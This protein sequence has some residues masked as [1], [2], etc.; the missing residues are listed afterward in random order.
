M[1]RR[2]PLFI[3]LAIISLTLIPAINHLVFRLGFGL[4]KLSTP[5]VNVCLF[6]PLVL[7]LGIFQCLGGKESSGFRSGM[8]YMVIGTIMITFALS[9][10]F[11]GV[12]V[13]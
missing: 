2:T 1:N 13:K 9:Y 10:A 8:W 3:V 4:Y 5:F 12:G 6:G 7:V 11:Y